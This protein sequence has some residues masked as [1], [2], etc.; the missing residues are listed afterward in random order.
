M[1][2]WAIWGALVAGALA[3]GGATAFLAVRALEAW[4][5]LKRLRR[6]VAGGLE[7]LASAGEKTAERAAAAADTTQLERSLGRLRGSLA[8]LAVLRRA[9]EDV[10][11][12][13]PRILWGLARR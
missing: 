12:A 1:W 6:R 13:W 5:R 4:R 11:D 7:A 9:L 10:Q 3:V 2:D 8:Q